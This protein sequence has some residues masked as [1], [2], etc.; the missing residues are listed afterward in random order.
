MDP[1]TPFLDFGDLHRLLDS[2]FDAD[3]P[4]AVGYV[5]S[6]T[7]G[8]GATEVTEVTWPHFDRDLRGVWLPTE[9]WVP[10]IRELVPTRAR[11]PIGPR[12]AA[13]LDWHRRQQ[14]QAAKAAGPVWKNPAQLVFTDGTGRPW[15]IGDLDRR[16]HHRCRAAG[17][18]PR[19]WRTLKT[20]A[21][22]EM[23][24]L[25][26][27]PCARDAWRRPSGSPTGKRLLSHTADQIDEATLAPVSA[28]FA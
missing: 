26:V 18:D 17:L 13:A 10:E 2:A 27:R 6:L 9:E 1:N 14:E 12:T 7:I 28:P 15:S 22:I 25:G 4:L 11:H 24:S 8:L 3:D 16:L 19:N 20:A 5:S 23:I 21:L